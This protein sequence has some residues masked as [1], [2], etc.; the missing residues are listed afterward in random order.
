MEKNS[1]MEERAARFSYFSE[2]V[3]ALPTPGTTEEVRNEIKY[4]SKR[5]STISSDIRS[6]TETLLALQKEFTFYANYKHSLEKTIVPITLLTSPS[7]RK[8]K[9]E[10]LL[11]ILEDLSPE[12]QEK[13]KRFIEEGE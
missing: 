12:R 4:L 10:S 9:E 1:V 13:L 8:E 6:T 7:Q 11:D 3:R 5:M 2:F